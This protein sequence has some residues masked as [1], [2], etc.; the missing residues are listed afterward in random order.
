[1]TVKSVRPWPA[2]HMADQYDEVYMENEFGMSYTYLTLNTHNLRAGMLVQVEFSAA[3]K[4]VRQVD[5]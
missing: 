2:P 1:M 4:E 5:F 3:V